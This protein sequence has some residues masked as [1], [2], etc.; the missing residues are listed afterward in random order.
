MFQ[1]EKI[2]VSILNLHANVPQ[3]STMHMHPISL[4]LKRYY[5]G[6]LPL[7]L[8]R[9]TNRMT[10][11]PAK[12]V[13]S[14]QDPLSKMSKS[15]PNPK[16]RI[17]ITD[18]AEDIGRK[19]MAAVTDSTNSVS[20]DPVTR[21]G[22]SNLLLLLSHFDKAGRTPSE[23]ASTFTGI[24]LKDFKATVADAIIKNLSSIRTRFQEVLS[25]GGGKYLDQIA[26]KGA[27]KARRNAEETMTLV[28]GSVG[29]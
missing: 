29:F 8:C 27:E 3:I 26:D 13:M 1:L 17:L 15:N 28:R 9:L 7:Y 21:P 25:E 22:V 24:G 20:Y 14:L 19:I 6:G 4:H 11:A 18:E 16:S 10:V 2:K 5:V 23:L 12:R